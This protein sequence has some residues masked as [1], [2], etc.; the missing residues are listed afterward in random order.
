MSIKVEEDFGGRMRP[1]EGFVSAD[2]L[3]DVGLG[4]RDQH[5]GV[6]DDTPVRSATPVVH[7]VS[8]ALLALPSSGPLLLATE[9]LEL[10]VPE[11]LVADAQSV[12]AQVSV[13]I[14]QQ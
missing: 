4:R 2:L 3:L 5:C 7:G 8:L 9:A 11:R 10:A 1:G 6:M 14:R 12:L 13:H